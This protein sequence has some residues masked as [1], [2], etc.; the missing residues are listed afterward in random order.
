MECVVRIGSKMLRTSNL[1][2]IEEF[3]LLAAAFNHHTVD[4]NPSCCCS[5]TQFEERESKVT[6]KFKL[7]LT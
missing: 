6:T 1:K 5:R 2:S 3:S 7:K 4:K